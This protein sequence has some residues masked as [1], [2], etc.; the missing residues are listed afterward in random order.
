MTTEDDHDNVVGMPLPKP[1]EI[2]PKGTA[3]LRVVVNQYSK[4]P[5]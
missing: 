2:R 5:R 3:E 4:R 1:Q